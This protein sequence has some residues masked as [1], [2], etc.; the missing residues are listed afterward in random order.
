MSVSC[1]E[2]L[3]GGLDFLRHGELDERKDPQSLAFIVPNHASEDVT[4]VK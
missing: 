3:H 1:V 2:E 4:D